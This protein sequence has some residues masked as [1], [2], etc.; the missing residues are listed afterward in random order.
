M[1]GLFGVMKGATRCVSRPLL[2]L[3]LFVFIL[4]CAEDGCEVS[5]RELREDFVLFVCLGLEDCHGSDVGGDGCDCGDYGVVG[6]YGGC[7]GCECR[8]D[9]V[10]GGEDTVNGADGDDIAGVC[11]VCGVGFFLCGGGFVDEAVDEVVEC[12]VGVGVHCRSPFCLFVFFR[13]HLY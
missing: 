9:D 8:G 3:F 5:A 10:C 7:D 1:F 2:V 11:G 12:F 6:E 13:Q 4:P